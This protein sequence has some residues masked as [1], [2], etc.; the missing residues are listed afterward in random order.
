MIFD[1]LSTIFRPFCGGFQPFFASFRWL[2]GL[3]LPVFASGATLYD[4]ELR[5]EVD[6]MGRVQKELNHLLSAS[7]A[8]L[9]SGYLPQYPTGPA[10]CDGSQLACPGDGSDPC[11]ALQNCSAGGYNDCFGKFK[12]F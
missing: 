3:F 11:A 10:T 2:R 1:D 6:V 8:E 9:S 4:R 7:F 12:A 5:V